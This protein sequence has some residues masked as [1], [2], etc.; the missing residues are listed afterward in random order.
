MFL[1][2]PRGCEA[3]NSL[4]PWAISPSHPAGCPLPA[5]CFLSWVCVVLPPYSMRALLWAVGEQ[6]S[7]QEG[8]PV[9]TLTARCAV[10][11]CLG[12]LPLL[13][14]TPVSAKGLQL[15]AGARQGFS[16]SL[17]APGPVKG[18]CRPLWWL[19]RLVCVPWL[20]AAAYALALFPTANSCGAGC[21]PLAGRWDSVFHYSISLDTCANRLVL[22]AGATSEPAGCSSPLS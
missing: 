21:H 3:E 11:S 9:H 20:R 10:K 6:P 18:S 17:E 12:A 14:K 8:A 22:R 5:V 13:P 1:G 4:V 7:V 2:S 15:A 19:C 16:S